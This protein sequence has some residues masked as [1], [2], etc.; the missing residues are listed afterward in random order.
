MYA[1]YAD[2]NPIYAP[3][4]VNQGYAISNPK[5]TIE[6]NKAGSL[7]FIIPPTNPMYG[8]LQ[9]LKSIITIEQDGVEIWRGRVLNDE[10]DFY[11]NKTIFCEGELAFLNDGVVPPYDY[12]TGT[13][14]ETYFDFLVGCYSSK[15]SDYRKI[16]AGTVSDSLKNIEISVKSE[17]YTVVLTELTSKLIGAIGGYLKIR[18]ENGISY[19]DYVDSFS[20]VSSQVIQFGKNLIDLEEYIDA[21]EVYTYMIPLGKKNEDGSRIDITSVNNNVNYIYSETGESLFGKIFRPIV[22]ED[23]EDPQ[24]LK[25]QA[26]MLLEQAI[27]MAITITISAVDMHLLDVD[28]DAIDISEFIPVVSVPHGINSNFLCSK[29]VL[30]L[31]DPSQTEY[32]LGLVFSA[33][34][35]KQVSSL[36]MSSDAYTVSQ[37]TADAYNAFQAEAYKNYVSTAT[38]TAFKG[39]TEERLDTLE[40]DLGTVY[41]YKGSVSSY[42]TLPTEGQEN[43]DVWNV[44]DT[45]ANYAWT[46]GAFW[47]KLSETIDLTGY[48]TKEEYETLEARVEAL[49]GGT[50]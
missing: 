15:C 8:S 24:T 13:T 43:G 39:E 47:D 35:D 18:R 14:V 21:S 4:I 34:T 11:K 28:T 40:G 29:I 36:K 42:D 16:L 44:L 31:M 20:Q 1:I 30:N 37:E 22:W 38:F 33:L 3:N 32:T 41:R 9:K 27:E 25:E 49:E 48:V 5:M 10:A 17:E 6:L 50:T 45:G 46:D 7:D 23:I 19:L 2:G 12:S 26:E